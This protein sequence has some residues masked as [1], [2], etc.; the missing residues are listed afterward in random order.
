MHVSI[1]IHNCSISGMTL[2]A[3]LHQRCDGVRGDSEVPG[4]C[5]RS[6]Q[7]T[8]SSI[9]KTRIHQSDYLRET[10]YSSLAR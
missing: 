7:L 1:L 5:D 3:G 10:N 2:R 8:V 9:T 4:T 6:D